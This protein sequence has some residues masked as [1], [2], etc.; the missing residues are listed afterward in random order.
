MIDK[1]EATVFY[2]IDHERGLLGGNSRATEASPAER[3][4]AEKIATY[5]ICTMNDN[6][7]CIGLVIKTF[8]QAIDSQSESM[9]SMICA[10]SNI[11][12]K[13]TF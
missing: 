3:I 1:K 2:C 8:L 7:S 6:I 12:P 10:R 5:I 9:T 4:I 11:K 13:A